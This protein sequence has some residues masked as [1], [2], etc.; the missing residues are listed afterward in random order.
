MFKSWK[1]EKRKHII[2]ALKSHRLEI[3]VGPAPLDE[4]VHTM[5][6][7]C[8]LREGWEHLARGGHQ[9]GLTLSLSFFSPLL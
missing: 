2:R 1:K 6:G 3:H 4:E 8:V 9:L 5:P 7:R